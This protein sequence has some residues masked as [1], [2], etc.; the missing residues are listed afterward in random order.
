MLFSTRPTVPSLSITFTDGT[1]LEKVDEFKYLGLWLDPQL[2]FKTHITSVIQKVNFSLKVL[3]RSIN[4]FTFYV[5]KRIISQLILPIIDYGD[6]I[7]QNTS[8]THLH[9]LKVT[10]NNLCRFILR[11]PYM[12]HHCSMYASLNWLTPQARRHYHWL[13]FIFKCIHNNYPDYLKQYI[14]PFNSPYNLRHT[15]FPYLTVPTNIRKEAGRRAFK[16]KAPADWNLLPSTIRSI[17]SLNT[18]K[19]SIFNHLQLPCT[20]Y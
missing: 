18:F 13:T 12:T 15:D 5:R 9:P 2:S 1:L 4:C 7:Y 14:R 6:I 16:Y 11:C 20:C 3:Y 8:D 19:V 17:T 10:Y